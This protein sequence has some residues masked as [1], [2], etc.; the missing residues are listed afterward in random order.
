VMSV[1]FRLSLPPVV[2]RRA[3]IF[4]RLFVFAY[5]QWCPTYIV[6]CFSYDCRHLLDCPFLIAPS[7]IPNV[8]L[9]NTDNKLNTFQDQE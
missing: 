2:C 8:Y 3:H 7:V 6:L 9:D 5:A 1:P 4:F